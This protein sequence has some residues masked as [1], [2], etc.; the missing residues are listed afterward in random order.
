MAT[1]PMK[2]QPLHNF[3]LP[4]LK[5]GTHHQN[6]NRNPPSTDTSEPDDNNNNDSTRHHRVV[7]SRSSRVQRLSFTSS[8]I[9]PHN[10]AVERVQKQK[11]V[12]EKDSIEKV[13]KEPAVVEKNETEEEEEEEGEVVGKPWNLRPRK[14]QETLFNAEVLENHNNNS[15]VN[16]KAPKSTRLREMESRG[17]NGE[18]KEKSK[19]WLTLSRDEV[20]ED[21]FIMTGSRPA[22]RPRK[23]PKNI[24]KQVDNVFPG[25]WLVGLTADSYRVADAPVKK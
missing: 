19:F 18:K 23:R 3:S 16:M 24:Q 12:S 7:G 14:V 15:S 21:I 9:K 13:L 20:E 6:R 17:N 5:W 22:R 4:F 10:D 25:L 8:T 11:S 1:A 2:S